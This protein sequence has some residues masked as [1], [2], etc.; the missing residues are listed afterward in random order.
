MIKR[1]ARR[2]LTLSRH[3][4]T[5][6]VYQRARR[7]QDIERIALV[8]NHEREHAAWPQ[9]GI[10]FAKPSDHVR[11]VLYDVT[12]DTVI[13]LPAPDAFAQ[14]ALAPDKIHVHDHVYVD[15]G[16][17]RVGFAKFRRCRPVDIEDPA[18]LAG[19]DRSRQRAYFNAAPIGNV[20]LRKRLLYAIH[21]LNSRRLDVG[22]PP[23]ESK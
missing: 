17:G 9:Y 6:G 16:L 4:S 8:G 11:H 14:R 22:W 7:P 18:L 20:N 13:E 3:I 2:R 10:H 1:L 23:L 12:R 19:D 21:G 15:M 5:D